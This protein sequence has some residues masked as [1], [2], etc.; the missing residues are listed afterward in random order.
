MNKNRV[1]A[2]NG[3]MGK[4]FNNIQMNN[5]NNNNNAQSE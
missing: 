2:Y 5:D 4:T 3:G 1:P